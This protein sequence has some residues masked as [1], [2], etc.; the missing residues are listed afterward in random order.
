M[1]GPDDV[2]P[3]PD[4]AWVAF[5]L[6]DDLGQP[7]AGEAFRLQ[8]PDGAIV[9][10]VL[11]EDG[12]AYIERIPPGGCRL[13]LTDIDAGDL[14]VEHAEPVVEAPERAW[15]A[16]TLVDDLGAPQE[17]TPTTS[18]WRRSPS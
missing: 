11:D 10:G 1:L 3:G 12:A 13:W 7:A 4:D 17:S 14:L 6:V 15:L 9:E 5:R 8:L 18:G 16:F 2:P